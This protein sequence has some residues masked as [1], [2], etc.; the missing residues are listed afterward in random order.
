MRVFGAQVQPEWAGWSFTFTSCQHTTV[1]YTLMYCIIFH[2]EQKLTP[3]FFPPWYDPRF[4]Q[5]RDSKLTKHFL[6]VSSPQTD[7][8]LLV[9]FLSSTQFPNIRCSLVAEKMLISKII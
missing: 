4:Y 8:D 1:F 7:R 2:D 5:I 6:F 9:F 3:M